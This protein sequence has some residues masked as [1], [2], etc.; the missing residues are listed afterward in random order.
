[1]TVIRQRSIA[2]LLGT[3]LVSTTGVQTGQAETPDPTILRKVARVQLAQSIRAFA[4]STLANGQCL[5]ARGRLSQDEV[6]K[7]MPIALREIGISA[8]VLNNPQVRRAAE[9]LQSDLDGDCGFS[10]LE[11]SRAR[12]LVQDEL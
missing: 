9:M 8:T 5:V 2:I 12:K 7:A 6:A 3:L 1:M 11:E 10:T 4:A